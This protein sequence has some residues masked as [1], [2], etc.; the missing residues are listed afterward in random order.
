VGR[1]DG[2]GR[3]SAALITG[4]G[5]SVGIAAGIASRLA[6]DGWDLALSYWRL[7]TP[8]D[9][10]AIVSFLLSDDGAWTTGQLIHSDGGFSA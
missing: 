3:R 1:P 8:A 5:R 2:N 7:G 6:D 10:A 9:V 4:A